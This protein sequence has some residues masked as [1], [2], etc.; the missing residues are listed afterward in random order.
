MKKRY[1]YQKEK[2]AQRQ[3]LVKKNRIRT[4][5]KNH[6]SV[7]LIIISLFLNLIIS[8]TELF[9][10]IIKGDFESPKGIIK[11]FWWN[12]KV[13]DDTLKERKKV[14]LL[15]EV[16]EK[17]VLSQMRKIPFAIDIAIGIIKGK[18]SLPL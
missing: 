13:L 15:Y 1:F 2:L 18:Y 4:I 11:A 6:K 3:F 14:Q 10:L 16:S 5:I 7:Y 12:I 17:Y 9:L 8:F